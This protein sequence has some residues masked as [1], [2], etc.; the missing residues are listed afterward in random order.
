MAEGAEGNG[1]L[2]S[3]AVREPAAI[4]A[5]LPILPVHRLDAA[6]RACETPAVVPGSA[7]AATRHFA[8][9]FGRLVADEL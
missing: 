8:P 2:I 9:P 7:R 5:G 3:A 6:N 1:Y 4:A